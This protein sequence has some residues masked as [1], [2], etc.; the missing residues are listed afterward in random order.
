[1]I[2]ANSNEGMPEAEGSSAPFP[3]SDTVKARVV[4]YSLEEMM[5]ELEVERVAADV[6]REIVDQS[7]IKGLFAKNAKK[8]KKRVDD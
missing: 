5:K 2:T 8:K 1:M 7:E 4:R 6:G 3:T